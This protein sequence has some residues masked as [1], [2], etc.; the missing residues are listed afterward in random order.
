M[1]IPS[2]ATV[3]IEELAVISALGI[4]TVVKDI[5]HLLGC[6]SPPQVMCQGWYTSIV[7]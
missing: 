3:S 6:I 7:S 1:E 5:G 4:S 2:D